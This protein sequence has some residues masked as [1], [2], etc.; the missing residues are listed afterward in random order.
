MEDSV[1]ILSLAA[2]TSF[3]PQGTQPQIR[4]ENPARKI[5]SESQTKE[6]DLRVPGHHY[7]GL[8]A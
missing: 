5:G 3:K 6:P 4:V 2:M 1:K 8:L 7:L